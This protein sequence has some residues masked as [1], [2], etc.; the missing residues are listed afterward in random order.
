[1]V[2][3]V[4]RVR[5]AYTSVSGTWTYLNAQEQ[6]QIPERVSSAV[7]RGFRSAPLAAEIERGAGSHALLQRAGRFI[8][9]DHFYSA[10]M[11]IADMTGTSADA[12]LLGPSRDVLLHGYPARCGHC[13]AGDLPLCFRAQIPV[14]LI[15]TQKYVG[16]NLT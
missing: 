1:M 13:C 7:S 6:P 4:A 3:D 14:V 10:R 5:G 9:D 2:F 15:W 12:V 8:A 11:A 16:R